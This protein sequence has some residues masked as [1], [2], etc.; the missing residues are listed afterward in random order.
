MSGKRTPFR[1]PARP[2]RKGAGLSLL[3]RAASTGQVD[4][5]VDLHEV[6]WRERQPQIVRGQRVVEVDLARLQ[7]VHAVGAAWLQH[8]T[9]LYWYRVEFGL[10]REHG[11]L[12]M[13]GSGIV[14]SSGVSGS[15]R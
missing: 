15:G 9:G 6:E 2:A 12:R 1:V 3:C 14:S 13:Y 4:L 7:R 5:G 8:L 10:I 11:E